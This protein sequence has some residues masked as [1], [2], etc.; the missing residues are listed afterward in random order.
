MKQKKFLQIVGKRIREVRKE[1]KLSQEKLGELA[2]LSSPY[3]SDIENGKVNGSLLSYYQIAKALKVTLSSL[4]FNINTSDKKTEAELI[5][6][7]S[8]V[9]IFE[10]KKN[11]FFR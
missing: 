8:Q 9:R 7:F 5:E 6:L 11:D 10:Q 1:K 3:I 2:N 4:V